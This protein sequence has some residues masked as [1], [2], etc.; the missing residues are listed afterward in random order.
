MRHLYGISLKKEELSCK[1]KL[2][3]AKLLLGHGQEDE[4]DCI[5]QSINEQL[6]KEQRLPRY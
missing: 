3:F 2:L 5:I 6:E 4:V 1:K